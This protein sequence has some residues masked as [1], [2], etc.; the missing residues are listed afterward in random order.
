MTL[1]FPTSAPSSAERL[2]AICDVTDSAMLPVQL[3]AVY[4]HNAAEAASTVVG[5]GAKLLRM[6]WCDSRRRDHIFAEVRE[7]DG[8]VWRLRA[9]SVV[10][11]AAA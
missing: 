8:R 11:E 9:I 4:A 7:L 2:Y 10:A 3:G 5:A 6:R 1:P